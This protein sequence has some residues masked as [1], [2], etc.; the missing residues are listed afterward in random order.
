MKEAKFETID[1]VLFVVIPLL[2]LFLI[3]LASTKLALILFLILFFVLFLNY[4]MR[5]H[6]EYLLRKAKERR[7]YASVTSNIIELKDRIKDFKEKGIKTDEL[8]LILGKVKKEMIKV[9]NENISFLLSEGLESR[10]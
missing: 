7:T 3:S 4:A 8:E 5:S 2:C 10:K 9:K 1:N 6:A